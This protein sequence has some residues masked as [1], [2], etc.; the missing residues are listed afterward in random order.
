MSTH[1]LSASELRSRMAQVLSL[2]KKD[3]APCFVTKSGKAVAALLP[4]EIY[5][6][7]ISAL[8]DRLDEGDSALVSEVREARREY[9][10]KKTVPLSALKRLL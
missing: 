4:I 2:I 7:L 9:G 10:T 3:G 8:E 6:Q 5:D 1:I